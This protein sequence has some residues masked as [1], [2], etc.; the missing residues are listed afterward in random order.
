M[1]STKERLLLTGGTGFLGT[2]LKKALTDKFEITTLG[3][4]N[5][6]IIQVDLGASVPKFEAEFQVILHNAG[7]A[8]MVPRTSAEK[9]A[10]FNVNV[11]GTRHL[12]Q[13]IE[14]GSKQPKSFIFISTI[15]VYGK[16]S[17]TLISEEHPLEGS[18]PYA[19]SKIQAELLIKEWCEQRN[20]P[21]VFLR[22][23]LIIGP[24]APG[25]LQAITN[26]IQRNRY[27]SIK[28]NEARKSAVLAKDVAQLIPS[29]IGK[30]GIYNLTDGQ[31]P[32]FSAI[33]TA[34]AQSLNKKIRIQI[35]LN[36]LKVVAL[37]G[38]LLNNFKIPFPLHSERLK[39]MTAT[40]T[41]SDKKAQRELNWNPNSVI[42]YIE[43]GK[44]L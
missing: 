27:A 16:D 14:Q 22:L 37:G 30:T 21:Y 28:G 7:K 32:M 19:Q 6:N 29:L 18:S 26:A 25:N 11:E 33:E 13:A 10:F 17:G 20:I 5:G 12:L 35:P 2:I 41:F 9:E 31:H 34:I 39:K 1:Q 44:A 42:T 4:S 3:R 8:H 38:D 23:P 36:V 43:Q 15:A 40:L 24:Q